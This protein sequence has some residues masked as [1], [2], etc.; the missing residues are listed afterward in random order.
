MR[1]LGPSLQWFCHERPTDLQLHCINKV[2]VL[3]RTLRAIISASVNMNT[4]FYLRIQK[5]CQNW[6]EKLLDKLSERTRR[7]E[8]MIEN[9]NLMCGEIH[10]YS[11]LPSH[12][13][14]AK[15]TKRNRHEKKGPQHANCHHVSSFKTFTRFR[16][17]LVSSQLFTAWLVLTCGCVCTLSSSSDSKAILS[18]ELFPV[19]H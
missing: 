7:E 10:H 3:F 19:S 4:L 14:L 13:Q 16:F 1:A 15:I 8:F 5:S 11:F 6:E 18:L 9:I 17:I 12:K 2:S